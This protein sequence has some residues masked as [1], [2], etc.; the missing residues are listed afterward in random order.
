MYSISGIKIRHVDRNNKNL[1][2]RY[3]RCCD[4]RRRSEFG[5]SLLALASVTLLSIVS[6]V[7]AQ[8]TADTKPLYKTSYPVIDFHHHC[9]TPSL[10]AIEAN[11]EVFDAVGVDKLAVLDG[12]WT[13]S[14]LFEWVEI[15]KKHPDRLVLFANVDFSD[16]DK[17][18]YS[19]D[20]VTEVVAQHH[21]GVQA[22]KIYKSLGLFVRDRK[23]DLMPVDDDRLDPFWSKCGDLGLPVL[24][25]TADPKE[26]F[27]PRT[28]NSF[29]YGV[30]NRDGK[31]PERDKWEAFGEPEYW[32]DPKMPIFAE[33]M[34]QRDHV[35]EKHPD[36]IFVG[37][38]MGSLTF[39][40]QR[41]GETLDRYPNFYVEC[42]A[43]LRILGRL[44]PHAV[45]DFFV[46]YQDRILYGSDSTSLMNTDPDDPKA[47]ERWKERSKYLY[48]RHFEYFET[49]HTDIIEPFGH[50]QHWLR[51]AG[52]KLPS[53]VL[54][55]FY[56]RNAMKIIP[57][58]QD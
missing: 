38:H 7:A 21:L 15:Y 48:G 56:Y 16:V 2:R 24:I 36:T 18:T 13:K 25:H 35:L 50:Q 31:T 1:V 5:R 52:V 42:S 55:K 23:G 47:V 53:E 37:A 8:S 28:Y 45:R 20:L 30:P 49:D 41:L 4:V 9:D 27:F 44:N 51:L 54:E 40:L 3:N 58:L 11:L 10:K 17:P 39:D 29:H 19:Q 6:N 32:K 57:S 22:I 12:G 34:K 14:T 43:R 33:L 46:K 26:Y